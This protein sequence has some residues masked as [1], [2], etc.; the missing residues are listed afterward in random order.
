MQISIDV[1]AN[2]RPKDL[3][4]LNHTWSGM[5]RRCHDQKHG[6][7]KYYGARGVTVCEQW[8]LNRFWFYAWALS[9]GYADGLTIDRIDSDGNYEPTNCR[10]ATR[11]EQVSNRRP[12][13][14]SHRVPKTGFVGIRT[15]RGGR[16]TASVCKNG[17]RFYLG[18]F[19][20][21]EEAA[22]A[23]DSKAR[24]LFGE[25]AYQNFQ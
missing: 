23:Y 22:R 14:R 15:M 19:S 7:H 4:R 21:K 8:R 11:A 10:W 1:F 24:E 20:T 17:K 25:L 13:A 18:G 9:N 3:V 5:V 2:M 16:W 12:I 6:G